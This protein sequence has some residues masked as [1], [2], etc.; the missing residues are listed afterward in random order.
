MARQTNTTG[1]VGWIYFAGI[2]MLI[3]AILGL[4][5]GFAGIFLGSTSVL[6]ANGSVE[7][8]FDYQTWGWI[9]LIVSVFVLW[10]ALSLL[11]GG[12]FGRVYA[13]LA[14]VF[15]AII[16]IGYVP[17]YPFWGIIALA[18]YLLVIYAVIVHGDE[19]RVE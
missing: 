2:L 8:V 14:A 4:F 17:M 5:A 16:A 10:A 18:I 11:R 13:T 19:A 6:Y 12:I 1:W 3:N 7:W 9:H 15:G